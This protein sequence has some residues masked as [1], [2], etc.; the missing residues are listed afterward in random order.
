MQRPAE[1][2]SSRGKLDSPRSLRIDCV[3]SIM[4]S[5]RSKPF[6]MSER[7]FKRFEQT[8]QRGRL[9]RDH[10]FG[11]RDDEIFREPA[12]RSLAQSAQKDRACGCCVRAAR[13]KTA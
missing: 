5:N 6:S 7:G 9:F 8:C 2:S 3:V 12:A 4:I 1:A 11:Q 13:A 10:D